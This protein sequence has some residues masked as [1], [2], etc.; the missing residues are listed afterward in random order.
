MTG[1]DD[2]DS[3]QQVAQELG[4]T[5]GA[6]RVA[7]HRWREDLRQAIREEI[8]QT[9]LDDREIDEELAHLMAVLS[10]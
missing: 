10:E 9:V 2:A 3:Q 7:L 8:R 1:A 5:V 6:I 4:L